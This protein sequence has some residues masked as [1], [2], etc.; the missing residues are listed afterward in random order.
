MAAVARSGPDPGRSR[1]FCVSVAAGTQ[2]LGLYSAAFP[3]ILAAWEAEQPGL[4][5]APVWDVSVQGAA[6][7]AALPSPKQQDEPRLWESRA[8]EGHAGNW[9]V[10]TL[11]GLL[12]VTASSLELGVIWLKWH[13]WGSGL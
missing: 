10:W 6:L 9:S 7:P 11:T 5:L 2:I 4:N 8:W 3:G 1:S 12:A 13:V